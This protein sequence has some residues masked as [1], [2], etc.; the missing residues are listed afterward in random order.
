MKLLKIKDNEQTRKTEFAQVLNV[1]QK[2]ADKTLEQLAKEGIF[3]LPEL[4]NDADDITKEQMI[5]QSC[6]D[7]YRSSNVMGFLGCGEERLI[8]T[9]RFSPDDN[10]YFLQ[11]LLEQ[12]FDFPNIVDLQTDSNQEN[13]LFNLLLF[14]FPRYLQQAMRK[15]AF[16]A[17]V[18]KEYNDASVKGTIDV[19]RHI[20][21]NIPFVGKIA[22]SQREYSYDNYLMELIRH[23]IE[24]I[25]K[26]AYGKHLLSEVK[27]EVNLVINATQ[28]YSACNKLKIIEENKKNPV[29]HA[30]YR[31][32]RTL[33]H[34]CLLILQY[35]KHQ[36]GAGTKQIYGILFDGA[37]LWEEYINVLVEDLFYHPMNKGGKD[38]QRLFSGN[39]GLIY[40]DFIS[41]NKDGRV[42]ADAKYKPMD[43]IGNKDYLQVL[44][45]MLRFDAKRGLYFYPDTQHTQSYT[46]WVNKGSTYESNVQ[47]RSDICVVKHGLHIPR[48]A[49][50]YVDFVQKIK[51]SEQIFKEQVTFYLNEGT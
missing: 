24:F 37:W 1:V 49:Q 8:I 14:L 40:P 10:D 15:G 2:V 44:A 13:R 47:P 38:A 28:N 26:K 45:Y 23:T 34:L 18:R 30:Y 3:V 32:Y 33:Q 20:K 19:A 5:L 25:K 9:S 29:R 6:N 42:I 46:L 21:K 12:I 17:Y 31:E 4:L 35:Q 39:I 27:D 48:T 11:Y 36:I 43:H 51:E 41:K 22:Y 16:K 7:F 50:S